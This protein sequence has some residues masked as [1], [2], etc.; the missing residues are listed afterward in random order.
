M[1]LSDYEKIRAEN[2]RQREQMFASL[3]IGQTK[4]EVAC[5]AKISKCKVG[6]SKKRKEQILPTRRSKRLERSKGAEEPPSRDVVKVT[7]EEDS[8]EEVEEEVGTVEERE[9]S[10]PLH[11][12]EVVTVE[13]RGASALPEEQYEPINDMLNDI[14]HGKI[15]FADDGRPHLKISRVGEGF[16]FIASSQLSPS[17]GQSHAGS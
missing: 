9:E 3:N 4:E 12:E 6:A 17:N 10:A 1:I 7:Q 14:N 8:E 2:I 11:E 15:I 16:S 13:E 5:D